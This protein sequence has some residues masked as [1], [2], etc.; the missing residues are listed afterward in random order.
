LLSSGLLVATLMCA[1]AGAHTSMRAADVYA[2]YGKEVALA[3]QRL[4]RAR[5][6][7]I[8][9][10]VFSAWLASRHAIVPEKALFAA[11]G[12][13]LALL[14]PPLALTFSARAQAA[15]AS[16]A[17]L[18]SLAT[19]AALA[20]ANGWAVGVTQ[21]PTIALIGAVAGFAVGWAASAFGTA[22]RENLE[23]AR[24]QLFIDSPFDPGGA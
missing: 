13:S 16:A 17:I 14:G 2:V 8:F 1:A 19:M 4:A 6:L 24:S 9:A 11:I 12:V 20:Y 5:G 18:A 7:A 21:A 23:P 10:V 15:H 3:S 22:R